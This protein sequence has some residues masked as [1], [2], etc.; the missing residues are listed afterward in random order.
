MVVY[1]EKT[2]L[3]CGKVFQPSSGNQVCCS[4]ACWLAQSNIKKNPEK[5]RERECPNCGKPVEN[6]PH[7]AGVR[8]YC[9]E[10]CKRAHY[11][12]KS[13]QSKMAEERLCPQC[14]KSFVR[15][16]GHQKYCSSDCWHENYNIVKHPEK[17]GELNCLACG[18]PIVND[19]HSH[20]RQLFCSDRCSSKYHD[21]KLKD[22]NRKPF[23]EK[24]C[25]HCGKA[26]VT[27]LPFQVCCSERCRSR[28]RNEHRAPGTHDEKVCPKCGNAFR[29]G[30]DTK[31]RQ[32]Y[33][34]DACMKETKLKR[35]SAALSGAKSE[36]KGC[37]ISFKQEL[38]RKQL[39]T[40]ANQQEGSGKQRRIL[41]MLGER[42]LCSLHRMIAFVRYKI[43]AD[44]CSGDLYVFCNRARTML[45]YFEWDGA[46]FC[47]GYRRT[48]SGT[49][50]WPWAKECATMEITEAEW[51]FLLHKSARTLM[52]TNREFP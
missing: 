35:D 25:L 49:I 2:C 34:C 20:G 11:H 12:R 21:Q 8:L 24:S 45:R 15:N 9:S 40:L 29:Q 22:K 37:I 19:P 48:H 31:G 26:F 38:W 36:Q 52:R 5:F 3:G 17:Y 27:N 28:R 14:G 46:E 50:P 44:P 10:K 4:R 23:V 16:S 1:K 7:R 39:A 41:L 33:C 47:A 42:D 43:N 32:R 6:D 51:A 30:Y 13:Y 18:A